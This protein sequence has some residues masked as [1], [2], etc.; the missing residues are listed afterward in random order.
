[1]KNFKILGNFFYFLFVPIDLTPQIRS[2]V[3]R[4]LEATLFF[5][6]YDV[7]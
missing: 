4:I 3:I 1:M 2:K 6:T 7:S 5:R